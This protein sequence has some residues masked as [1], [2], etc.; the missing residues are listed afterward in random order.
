MKINIEVDVSELPSN[1]KGEDQRFRIQV[2]VNGQLFEREHR[3]N[4]Y[5]RIHFG[6]SSL[7]SEAGEL[8]R[9]GLMYAGI[10][11]AETAVWDHS[12]SPARRLS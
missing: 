1:P 6:L 10:T 9:L 7:V 11:G 12:T 5:N 4:P 3:I 8:A 2:K